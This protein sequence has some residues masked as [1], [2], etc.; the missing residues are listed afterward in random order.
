MA[1]Y[2]ISALNSITSP[3]ADDVFIINDTS[4][5]ETTKNIKFSDLAVAVNATAPNAPG[6]G[7]GLSE[8]GGV[9]SVGAGS[10]ISVT[11]N[12]VNVRVDTNELEIANNNVSLKL[13]AD[14]TI[15][16]TDAGTTNLGNGIRVN[17]TSRI[18]V[19]PEQ[20]ANTPDYSS[21]TSE[22]LTGVIK[23]TLW[24]NTTPATPTLYVCTST[25]PL[26]WVAI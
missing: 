24:V 7:D 6:V 21:V 11:S 2:K 10:A 8:S 16:A 9:I 5:T 23:G 1:D 14:K 15:L 26:T 25:T 4:G 20:S 22:E 13:A 12:A 18:F 17:F 19:A 3:S